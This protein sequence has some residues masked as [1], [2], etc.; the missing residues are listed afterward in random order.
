MY[1]QMLTLFYHTFLRIHEDFIC[2][3]CPEDTNPQDCHDPGI[4][5]TYDWL[6][7]CK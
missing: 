1:Y 3:V 2:L 4:T 6:N 5:D 7:T